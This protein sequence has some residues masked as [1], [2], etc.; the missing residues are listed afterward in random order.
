MFQVVLVKQ[1]PDK[2]GL[3]IQHYYGGSM[4]EGWEFW[5][6]A[7]ALIPLVV[8][9]GGILIALMGMWTHT[10]QE[11]MR[12]RERLA[13]IER[14][15]MPPPERDPAAFEVMRRGGSRSNRHTNMGV[16][17]IALGLGLAL[18]IGFAGD[19]PGTAVGVGGAIALL[20]VAFV[21]NGQLQRERYISPSTASSMSPPPSPVVPPDP[22][23]TIA[24]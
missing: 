14:G 10:K 3:I 1:L 23:G 11:E 18:I 7:A 22:P 15:L 24:P 21:V 19:E 6:V 5:M 13:M 20:G 8:I 4:S 2:A 9:A 16:I 17:L 12:H